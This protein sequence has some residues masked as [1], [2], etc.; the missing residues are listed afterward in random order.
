MRLVAH[1]LVSDERRVWTEFFDGV[2]G[3]G[4][5]PPFPPQP[6]VCGWHRESDCSTRQLEFGAAEETAK[7]RRTTCWK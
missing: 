5:I 4:H 7:R 1:P 6:K 3:I 2:V